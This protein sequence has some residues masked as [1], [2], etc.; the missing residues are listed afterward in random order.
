MRV[1]WLP[2]QETH[3]HVS[4]SKKNYSLIYEWTSL[5][6][7]HGGL[8]LAHSFLTEFASRVQLA[9]NFIF[10]SEKVWS[11][12]SFIDKVRT[13]PFLRSHTPYKEEAL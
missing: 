7:R 13:V 4:I 1:H 9:V 10:I 3:I 6:A 11:D 12:N 5:L 8:T 2:V